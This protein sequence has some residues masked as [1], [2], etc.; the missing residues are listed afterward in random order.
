VHVKL[1]NIGEGTVRRI[2]R[3]HREGRD[4]EDISDWREGFGIPR[5]AGRI[6]GAF[7]AE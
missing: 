6:S 5:N 3:L 1:L 4:G 2:S 7:V